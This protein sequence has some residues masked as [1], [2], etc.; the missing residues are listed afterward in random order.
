MKKALCILSGGMDSALCAYL[1][2]K[3]G[4]EIVAIHF[5]YGQRTQK[6]EKECFEAI[7]KELQVYKSYSLDI[8]FL[9]VIGG[10]AL[11][12][13][14]LAVPKNELGKVG[15]VPI[16]YV[17]FRNGVFLSIAG[18]IAEKEECERIYIG[19][20][21]ADGSGYPDCTGDFIKK[22]QEFINKGTKECYSVEIC[23]P[24]LKMKKV[25]IVKKSLELGV[26]LELTWSCYE[27]EDEACGE[28]DSCL[29]RLRG[30]REAQKEDKIPYK[31]SP[32]SL[33]VI[34]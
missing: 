24:L 32:N 20:I 19:V 15:E 28:C 5:N 21:E 33:N 25:D 17:P 27:G 16:T 6:K 23:T 1:A 11:V 26:P 14:N 7:C 9:K 22:A 2:K 29:L 13:T 10:N 30:F 18:S 31:N 12:D 34:F 4:Y 3:E 8:D